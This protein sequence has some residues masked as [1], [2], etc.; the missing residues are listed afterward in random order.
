MNDI[1]IALAILSAMI[2]PAVLILACGSLILTTSQR[3]SRVIERERKLAKD[4]LEHAQARAETQAASPLLEEERALLYQQLSRT[5][6]RTRLLQQAMTF[7][8]LA[9]SSFVGVVVVIGLAEITGLEY[10]WVPILLGIIGAGLLFYA[11]LLLIIESRI[12]LI[13]VNQEM[14]FVLRVSK[15]Y[16]PDEISKHRRD[17]RRWLRGLRL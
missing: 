13:A 11:S 2:T 17:R 12:A 1:S 4:F 8:Y 3:L 6:K 7:L 14:D 9:V 15:Q 10:A 16:A 5:T